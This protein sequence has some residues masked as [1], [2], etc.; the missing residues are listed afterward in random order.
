[1]ENSVHLFVVKI[2]YSN[3]VNTG[4]VITF[5]K[6]LMEEFWGLVVS[7]EHHSNNFY[8]CDVKCVPHKN[9]IVF[10]DTNSFKVWKIFH[11]TLHYIRF[12]SVQLWVGNLPS[13]HPMPI[14]TKPNI[15][16]NV[17]ECKSFYSFLSETWK[18]LTFRLLTNVEIK[19]WLIF[20]NTNFY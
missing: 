9:T 2:L 20:K 19:N 10:H 8:L 13:H 4:G 12:I 16:Q 3:I 17:R 7:H 14:L 6:V 1:M 11:T 18:N 15:Q 5:Q